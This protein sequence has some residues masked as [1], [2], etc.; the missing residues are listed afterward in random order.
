MKELPDPEILHGGLALIGGYMG[1]LLRIDLSREKV[2]TEPL[3]FE[4]AKKLFGGSAYGA[5]L[6]YKEVPASIDPLGPEN[7]LIIMT[8]PFTGTFVPGGTRASAVAKSPLTGIFGEA[9]S[10]GFFPSELKFAGFDGIV[11]EGRASSPIYLKIFDGR[12]ELLDASHL[13]GLDT[14]ETMERL[15]AELGDPRIRVACIGPAGERLV[16]LAAIIN[17][18]GR[19]FGRTGLGAVM[20]SK[21]L[22]AIAVRGRMRVP[23]ADKEAFGE[24]LKAF[25]DGIAKA[26]RAQS[27]RQYGTAGGVEVFEH[28]GN[29]PIKN[30]RQGTFPGASKITGST[31]AKTILK[32]PWACLGCPIACGREIE[33]KEGPYKGLAGPGPEYETIAMLG[34]M[35][36]NE[37]LDSIAKAND[38]CNRYGIDTISTGAVIAFAMECY[39]RGL[40]DK[41]DTGGI[42][43][44]WGNQEAII[45][46][47]ELIGRREGFGEILGKG[48]REASRQIGKGS[49]A[50][51]IH[52]KG[53]EA[54][55]HEPRRFKSMGL[56]YATSNRGA[57]HMQGLANCIERGLLMPEYGLNE[58]L[59]GFTIERKPEV[60]ILYQNLCSALD[61][62]CL[63]KFPVFGVTSFELVAKTY[64]AITGLPM[65]KEGILEAG[66]KAWNLKR[67]YN[68]LCGIRAKDDRL[69]DRFTNEPLP[70]GFAKGQVCELEPMLKRYYELRGWNPDNGS[71]NKAKIS[72]LGLDLS[73]LP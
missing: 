63:C 4:I 6:L 40:I 28:I 32:A 23:I 14:F 64:E 60:V 20:G 55:A 56:A 43:L 58:A 33:V 17:D 54:P 67:A 15:R 53:L 44:Q 36:L 21:G 12:A 3:D 11:V 10:A 68:F 9:S 25:R 71:P 65:D 1:S 39:E 70:D 46:L 42:D 19:A 22:K 45:R 31:M 41:S 24:C 37:N 38:L 7:H 18:D 72:D 52:V 29:L 49:E 13:W 51:A 35:C 34:S 16:R 73:G 26:P 2:D 66:D 61:A 8:G 5:W 69:P 57:C 30:W 59:D 47:T 27:F 62:L 48:V 50:F